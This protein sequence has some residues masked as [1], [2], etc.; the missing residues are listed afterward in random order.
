MRQAG[1]TF[2]RIR[3]LY[4]GLG[5]ALVAI[6]VGAVVLVTAGATT[7]IF[8]PPTLRQALDLSGE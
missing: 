6:L 4:V 2:N 8:A 3:P 7:F 5:I 1:R